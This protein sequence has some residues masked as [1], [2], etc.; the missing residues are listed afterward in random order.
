P[1]GL[2]GALLA[3][4]RPAVMGIL[5]VTPDSFSD[6]GRFFSP[7]LA[8]AQ[9]RRMAGE[10]ADI[11]DIGAESTRPYGGAK[12]VSFDDEIARLAPVLPGVIG[13]G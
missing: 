13:L 6:A 11:L 2:L 3:L 8:L 9:A 10:G 5:N 4:G 7:E 1:D 12:P